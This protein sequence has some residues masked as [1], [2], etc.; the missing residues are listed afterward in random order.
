MHCEAES[1]GWGGGGVVLIYRNRVRA[2]GTVAGT[3]I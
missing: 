1:G 3:L 2:C